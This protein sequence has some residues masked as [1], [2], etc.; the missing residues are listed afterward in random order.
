MNLFVLKKKKAKITLF[1]FCPLQTW[2]NYP[3]PEV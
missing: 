1:F 2:K 3:V